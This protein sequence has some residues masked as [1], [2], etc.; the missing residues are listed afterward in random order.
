MCG[1]HP[2]RGC[3]GL[4]TALRRAPPGL[5]VLHRVLWKRTLKMQ[6]AA[7]ILSVAV[8]GHHFSET[9]AAWAVGSWLRLLEAGVW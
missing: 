4:T 5:R 2:V 1:A 8:K 3:K 7:P 9:H 6:C